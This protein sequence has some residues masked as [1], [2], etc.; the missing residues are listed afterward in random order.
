MVGGGNRQRMP[1]RETERE[2]E[3]ERERETMEARRSM[4]GCIK[5]DRGRAKVRQKRAS[6]MEK[7]RKGRK[8]ARR[9]MKEDGET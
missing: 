8:D 4:E 2:R 5:S 1:A 6:E 3:R 9:R 7:E